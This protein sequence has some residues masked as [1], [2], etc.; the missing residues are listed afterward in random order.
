MKVNKFLAQRVANEATAKLQ[1][2]LDDLNEQLDNLLKEKAIDHIPDDVKDFFK[3]HP[4]YCRSDDNVNVSGVGFTQ[5][6]V[7]F[8]DKEIPINGKDITLNKESSKEVHK[9]VS[10]IEKITKDRDE[11]RSKIKNAL[12]GL[13]TYKRVQENLPE[14][15]QFLPD[16]AVT[17]TAL[18]IP[19]KDVRKELKDLGI[20]EPQVNG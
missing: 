2:Q 9:L 19:I 3:K 17:T 20:T 18:A 8:E 16:S 4:N 12:I 7:M 10:T 5:R 11:K 15:M 13:G 1:Q 6:W 14:L